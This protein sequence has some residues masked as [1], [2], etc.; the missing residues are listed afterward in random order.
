MVL[1]TI[2]HYN[3]SHT[4]PKAL[5]PKNSDMPKLRKNALWSLKLLTNL[6]SGPL[7]NPTS[8]YTLTINPSNH[9]PKGP[10]FST[11]TAAKD[12]A[13]PTVL[14]LHCDGQKRF[15]ITFSEYPVKG[16]M[17]GLSPPPMVPYTFQVFRLHLCSP[18]LSLTS[19]YGLHSWTT[20][21]SSCILPRHETTDAI[22]SLGL[23]TK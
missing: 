20:T 11:K 19:P 8:L 6:T 4:A 23:A 14:Q 18:K 22:H 3:L 1:L 2:L 15:F 7:E 12:D 5:T 13:F 17:P 10:C 16:P 21:Q 9:L